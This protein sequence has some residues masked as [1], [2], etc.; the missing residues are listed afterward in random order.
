MGNHAFYGTYLHGGQQIHL[1]Y[2]IPIRKGTTFVSHFKQDPE[3]GS[4]VI[5]GFK[6]KYED[7][8]ITATVNSNFKIMSILGFRTP[9]YGLK[10][11]AE[12][13]YTR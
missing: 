3:S 8:E 13:D 9:Y 12:V 4:Q 11:C 5:V 7:V 6:Q 10:L 2:I 1:G